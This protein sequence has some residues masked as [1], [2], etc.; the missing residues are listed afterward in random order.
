MDESAPL[1]PD[2]NNGTDAGNTFS[3]SSPTGETDTTSNESALLTRHEKA[4][5]IVDETMRGGVIK[6]ASDVP[7]SPAMRAHYLFYMNFSWIRRGAVII[8]VLLSFVEMPSWCSE[9]HGCQRSDDANMHLSGVPYFSPI[10]TMAIDIVALSVLI[11]FAILDLRLPTVRAEGFRRQHSALLG[12]LALNFVYVLIFGGYPPVRV[13]P[14][15]RACLPLYYWQPLSECF[16]AIFAVINPFSDV[17]VFVILFTFLFGWVVTTFFHDVPEAGGYFGNLGE[18]LYSAFTSLTTADWPMQVMGVLE[19]SKATA[20]LLVVF[21]VIGVFLLFNVLL[22]VVYNAYT[23]YIESLVLQKLRNRLCSI[24]IAFDVL[25]GP[26]NNGPVYLPDIKLLFRELRKNRNHAH[27]DE[28]VVEMV[29][30][31]LDDNADKTLSREEFLDIVEVLQLKFVVESESISPIQL[32]LPNIYNTA[33]WQ[34]VMNF[35]KSESFVYVIN[36]FMLSNVLVVG[37]ETT[38]DLQ[39]KDTPTSVLIFSALE[40]AFSV[41]YIIEMVLKI[42]TLGFDTY[43]R[44]IGNRFDFWVTWV[45]LMASTYVILPFVG[46]NQDLFRF[47]I[48]L[49]CL[50]LFELLAHFP[51]FRRLVHAFS[52]LI[53]ASVPL[54]TL[55]ALS[56]YVFSAL[57]TELF[58][59]LVYEGNP[60][61]NPDL[62]PRVDPFNAANYWALNFNDMA[63]GWFT[64]F[65]S[66][67]VGYLTE[68]AAA[69]ASASK[70]GNWTLIFFVS[71]FIVNTLIVS[72]CVVAFVVDLFVMEDESEEDPGLQA[73]QMRY[74]AHRVKVLKNKTTAHQVYATMFRER[75]E[76]IMQT[77]SESQGV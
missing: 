31:A 5:W 22:A 30:T 71:S 18:G 72:N 65:S 36:I 9:Y 40:C 33:W 48:I 16:M 28:D 6:S 52:V 41:V 35:V 23:N 75:V 51:R 44:D 21:V 13:A 53:P 34:N 39:D 10:A 24:G 76:Q 42:C 27:F 63:S 49:R 32:Y 19:A 8:L 68:I 50:R 11:G 37:V 29:F 7:P 73:L 61:L 55:F 15:L 74:G 38:M 58:G 62:Y 56:L 43:W 14:F 54:F 64:L 77:G 69:I 20:L 1:L 70:Y 59:G 57:G 3:Q 25:S 67:V 4:A 17:V 45:L 12:L 66:V 47:F 2:N 60:K 46:H 26:D